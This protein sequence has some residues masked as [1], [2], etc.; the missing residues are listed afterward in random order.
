L[1]TD[2]Q[3]RVLQA[4]TQAIEPAKVEAVLRQYGFQDVTKVTQARYREVSDRLKA[5]RSKP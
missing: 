1:I 3:I 4:I 2:G 5:E